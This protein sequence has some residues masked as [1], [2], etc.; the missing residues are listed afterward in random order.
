MTSLPFI[1]EGTKQ[2]R[3]LCE[4]ISSRSGGICILAFSRGKDSIPAWV[5][6]KQFFHTIHVYHLAAVPNLGWVNR[7][8]SYYER[9]FDTE[10]IRFTEGE[11]LH[12]LALKSFQLLGNYREVNELGLPQHYHRYDAMAEIVRAKMGCPEAWLAQAMLA[13]DNIFRRLNLLK[14]DADGNVTYE[15]A[16]VDKLKTFYPTF[17]WKLDQNVEA[18]VKNGISLPEDYLMDKRSITS[19]PHAGNIQ[20]MMDLYPED[21]EKFEELFPLIKA[22]WARNQFRKM[23]EVGNGV[24]KKTVAEAITPYKIRKLEEK[25]AELSG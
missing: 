4:E 17:D 24:A 25:V 2:S 7:S 18:I 6:L 15:G 12:N 1:P 16:I 13:N 20:R 14:K 22:T 9:V 21:F 5:W 19:L 8:L 10:I 23:K 3:L 11:V